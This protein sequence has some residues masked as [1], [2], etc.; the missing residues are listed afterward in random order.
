MPTAY[1]YSIMEKKTLQ[2]AR[3]KKI[4]KKV[5]NIFPERTESQGPNSTASWLAETS[6][7]GKQWN[8][9]WSTWEVNPSPYF[10]K[11]PK[12]LIHT[13]CTHWVQWVSSP[14][15]LR[16]SSNTVLDSVL[17]QPTQ[18]FWPALPSTLGSFLQGS[19]KDSWGSK[20]SSQ[21]IHF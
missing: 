12:P 15:W 13:C 5:Q 11:L 3:K 6:T 9:L 1:L 2:K 17:F 16:P 20:L 18:V 10:Q 4:L 7:L 21:I 8:G 19:L 14:A